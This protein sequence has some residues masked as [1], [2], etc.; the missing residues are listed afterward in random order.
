MPSRGYNCTD[1]LKQDPILG[2]IDKYRDQPGIRL[3]KASKMVSKS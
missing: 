2:I 1:S 3:I